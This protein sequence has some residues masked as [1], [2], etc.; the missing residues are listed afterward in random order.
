MAPELIQSAVGYETHS[1]SAFALVAL[2]ALAAAPA[3]AEVDLL[4]LP[5]TPA[6][7]SLPAGWE[8]RPVPG[9][10]APAFSVRGG[11]A[12]ALRVTGRSAAA[13]AY[14]RLEDPLA[15]G[16]GVLRWSWRALDLP[17]AS[18]L[19]DPE[20]D[21]SALRVYVVFGRPSL[22]G[23]ARAIFYSWGNREP[24]ALERPSFESDR[25]HVVRL[26]GAGEADGSWRDE[27]VR[28]FADY[29]RIWG[30]RPAAITAVGVIQDTDGT[31]GT[32]AAELRQLVWQ[33]AL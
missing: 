8:L 9:Q 6:G 25:M 14:R 5:A 1:V 21:D 19:R 20:R 28:P 3:A 2:L 22:L 13:F 30:G 11:D 18:D 16:A 31:G 27:T 12:A 24:R 17:A 15:P 29:R 4:R 7:A 32:A 10:D 23:G 26:A 33:P